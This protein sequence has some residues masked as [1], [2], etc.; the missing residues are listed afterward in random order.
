MDN[1]YA[2]IEDY[3][4]CP[5]CGVPAVDEAKCLFSGLSSTGDQKVTIWSYRCV[6]CLIKANNILPWSEVVR[7]SRQY[8]EW[9]I[10]IWETEEGTSV[11]RLEQTGQRLIHDFNGDT[12]FI[13]PGRAGQISVPS[14]YL[15]LATEHRPNVDG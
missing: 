8:H 4:E 9:L 5:F 1:P 15:P 6:P 11:E 12:F 14:R 13:S 7:H 3:N 10:A 2:F